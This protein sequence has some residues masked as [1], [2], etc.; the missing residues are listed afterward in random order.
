MGKRDLGLI[1]GPGEIRKPGVLWKALYLYGIFL[2][3]FF[4]LDVVVIRSAATNVGTG[5]DAQ[6]CQPE[7]FFGQLFNSL[8]TVPVPEY[9]VAGIFRDP[10]GRSQGHINKFKDF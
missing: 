9:H 1:R 2:P 6:T 5:I 10:D 4:D 8:V 7:F 3:G